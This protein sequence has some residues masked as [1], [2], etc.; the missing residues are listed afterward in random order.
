VCRS[1]GVSG[2][3]RDG[4]STIFLR[5]ALVRHGVLPERH[6]DKSVALAVFINHEVLRVPDGQDRLALRTFAVWKVQH[7]LALAE[8]QGRAKRTAE[9]YAR[10][11][12]RVAADLL[13]WLAQRDLTLADLQQEHVD[14]WLAQG[15]T[16]RARI[17]I[18]LA[19]AARRGI[20]RRLTV[21]APTTRRHVDPLDP[22]ERMR[23]LRRLLDDESLDLQDRVAGCLVLLFAQPIS[24]LVLLTKNDIHES[25]GQLFIRL[26]REPL[27]LPEP[28]ATLARQLTQRESAPASTGVKPDSSPWLFPGL[29]LDTP[30][31]EEAMRR[32]LRRLGITGRAARNAAAQQLAKTL[33]AAVLADML[34]VHETTAEDWTQLAGHDWAPYAASR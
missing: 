24:R 7:E 12:I 1:S 4:Q 10:T 5:A 13:A 30:L 14:Y 27:M 16:Q 20:T 33:P 8:R 23:L 25:K 6:H 17:R 3:R 2:R 21:P 15:S 26:G 28:L 29:R 19:W 34:G 32:R 22:H 11:L 31:H 9:H 18:F